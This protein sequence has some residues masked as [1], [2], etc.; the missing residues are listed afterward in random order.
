MV[1]RE[2]HISEIAKERVGHIVTSDYSQNSQRIKKESNSQNSHK[3]SKT[4]TNDYTASQRLLTNI[5]YE[6]CK[7]DKSK[8]NPKLARNKALYLASKLDNES[9][10][11]FYLKC[12]WNL[13]DQYLDRLLEISLKKNDPKMYFSKSAGRAMR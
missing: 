13:N 7:R 6:N 1:V 12:A 3:S 11:L 10:I 4:M 5:D 8:Y 9:R 2:Q